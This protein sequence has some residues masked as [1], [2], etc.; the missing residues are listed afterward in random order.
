MTLHRFFTPEINI[1]Q[2]NHEFDLNDRVSHHIQVL[3]LKENDKIII[4]DGNNG[5]SLARISVIKKKSVSIQVLQNTTL[6]RESKLNLHLMQCLA[7]SD[8]MDF[9]VQKATELGVKSIQLIDADRSILKFDDPK[10]L[11]KKMNHWNEISLHALQQ[12]GRTQMMK[13]LPPLKIQAIPHLENYENF[14]FLPKATKPLSQII[15]QDENKFKSL[16]LAL[17]IGPEGDFSDKEAIFLSNLK[18]AH[19]ASL[20]ARIL[21]TETAGMSVVSALHGLIGDF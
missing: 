9:I 2:I 19:V 13:L 10:R 21:R 5:E 1:S 17:W 11:E 4:F 7:S 20:G 6:S 8:R 3:R 14:I 18:N 16:D 15:K 12:S